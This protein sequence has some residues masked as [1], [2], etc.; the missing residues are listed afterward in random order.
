MN[1]RSNAVGSGIVIGFGAGF[2]IVALFIHML[3]QD[4][5]LLKEEIRM[6]LAKGDFTEEME[7]FWPTANY[8][9]IMFVFIVLGI[10]LVAIAVGHEIYQW[11][12]TR[13]KHTEGKR[14]EKEGKEGE[15]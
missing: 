14:N 6:L 10:V 4:I 9:H 5:E 3:G 11:G 8:E 1:Q 13:S 2:F 15:S 7:L 12:K